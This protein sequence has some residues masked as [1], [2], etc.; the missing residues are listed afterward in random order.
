MGMGHAGSGCPS[1]DRKVVGRR[2]GGMVP[3]AFPRRYRLHRAV[4]QQPPRS[5][6]SPPTTSG[7]GEGTISAA[8]ASA[9]PLLPPLHRPPPRPVR[10]SGRDRE[11]RERDGEDKDGS[12]ARVVW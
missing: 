3:V 12:D 8:A 4:A 7:G 2:E 1:S 10:E 11:A 9:G 6:A 5:A